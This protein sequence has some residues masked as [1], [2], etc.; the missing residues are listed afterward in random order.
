MGVDLRLDSRS[1]ARRPARN[2][3]SP[4]NS[5]RQSLT[6]HC[7][8]RRPWFQ[9]DGVRIPDPKPFGPEVL[10]KGNT[11]PRPYITYYPP[12]K[13]GEATK[14]VCSRTWIFIL[15]GIKALS[16]TPIQTG[17]CCWINW[18]QT[19]N[20]LPPLFSKRSRISYQGS[21]PVLPNRFEPNYMSSLLE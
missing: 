16:V 21:P 15:S 5:G 7:G 9:H 4:A 13:F 18:W 3:Y 1:L 20:F 11:V 14:H 12:L 2:P 8:H 17:F 6:L 10:W 19:W